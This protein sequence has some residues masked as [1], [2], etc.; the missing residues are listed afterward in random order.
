MWPDSVVEGLHIGE[1]ISLGAGPGGVVLEVDQL[2]FEA[3]EEIFCHSVVIGITL[4]GHALLDPIGLQPLPEGDR[5]VL[6]AP[7]TVKDEPLGRFAAAHCHVEGFQSQGSVDAVGKGIAHNFSGTQIL[8]DGQVEPAFPGGNVGDITHP[9]LIWLCKE[10][11]SLQKIGCNG[12]AVP[13][14]GCGLIR[15]VSR[16]NDPSN[17]HLT[18]DPLAGTAEFRLEHVVE[19]VQPQGRILL[20]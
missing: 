17:P 12:V 11:V 1:Y 7:V 15:P 3:A 16:R 6:D 13:G 9:G 18:V 20:V 2:A 5:G 14:V 8:D 10:E 19:A 4:A